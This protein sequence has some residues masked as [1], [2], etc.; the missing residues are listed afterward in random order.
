MFYLSI[1]E[2]LLYVKTRIKVFFL[3][4]NVK[5]LKSTHDWHAFLGRS[6]MN[7]TTTRLLWLLLVHTTTVQ[8]YYLTMIATMMVS[9]STSTSYYWTVHLLFLVV[10]TTT[11]SSSTSLSTSSLSLSS[12]SQKPKDVNFNS[13]RAGRRDFFQFVTTV[14]GSFVALG[15]PNDARADEAT[16]TATTAIPVSTTTATTTTVSALEAS[17]SASLYPVTYSD[18]EWM[19]M[20]SGAQYNI[21][22]RGGTERPFS[23]ILESEKRAGTFVC[24]GCNTPLFASEAKFNSRT[25]WPSFA[26]TIE[27]GAQTPKNTNAAMMVLAGAELKCKT[28]GGHL[29]DVFLDGKLFPGT[30]AFE[31]GKRYCI[32]G[33]AL[34]FQPSDEYNSEPLYGDLPPIPKKNVNEIELPK[35]LQPPKIVVY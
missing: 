6:E 3:D 28:C 12:P 30:V 17:A 34:I 13:G 22:R 35:F 4:L 11:P 2:I 8:Q 9:T 7:L 20:L 10:L 1:E 18:K 24:A 26:S 14:T 27:N 19:Y 23:S 15:R 21:L 5:R 25:G 29:G 32:D 33:T 31:S 16:V